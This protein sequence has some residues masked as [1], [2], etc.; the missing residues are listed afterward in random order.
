MSASV[1]VIAGEASGDL[2]AA[3][4]I[5]ELRQRDSS[6]TFY[7][8]GGPLCRQA[9]MDVVIDADSLSVV[10]LFEVVRQADELLT[11]YRRVRQLMER[12]KP[13][14]A[15][16]LDLPDF[17]LKMAA[18]LKRMGVPVVYY[19]SPQ[20]WAWRKG[21]VHA[22]KALVD[23][24]LVIYPFE[25][26]FYRRHGVDA[27]YV[28]NPLACQIAPRF[29]YRPQSEVIAS[30][31]LAIL[32]G[33]RRGEIRLHKD[34]LVEFSKQI[35]ARYPRAEMRVPAARSLPEGLVA[36]ALFDGEMTVESTDPQKVLAWAD[37]ALVASGTATLE[38]GLVGTPF[39][40]FYRLGTLTA[41]LGNALGVFRRHIGLVNILLG[42]D[43]VDER[44]MENATVQNCLLS[45][46]ALIESESLRE[47][48]VEGF[49]RIRALLG[50]RPASSG[51]ASAVQNLLLS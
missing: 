18:H 29:H 33:S 9:G 39:C 1:F 4:L 23:K 41:S 49:R 22:I 19:I 26:E 25:K 12:R 36:E 28:G 17:N 8:V 35:K 21:R 13:D 5:R 45:V 37:V 32:P 30:P 20:V 10:G 24:M 31:R 2:H 48:Q 11:S 50:D 34:L 46:S 42:E 38:T 47:K 51:A 44:R 16:L 15:I 40:L 27:E 14:L 3:H 6:L 43:L 7:G